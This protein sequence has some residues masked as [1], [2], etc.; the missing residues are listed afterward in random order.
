MTIVIDFGN[1]LYWLAIIFAVIS[2]LHVV[3]WFLRGASQPVTLKPGPRW[4]WRGARDFVLIAVVPT[5]IVLL[6]MVLQ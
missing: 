3:A 1:I 2:G 5:A 4:T 6:V